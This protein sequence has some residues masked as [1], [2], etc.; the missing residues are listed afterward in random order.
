MS[1]AQGKTWRIGIRKAEGRWIVEKP[2]GKPA[3]GIDCVEWTLHG[4]KGA[5][6]SAHFQFTNM[7]L[8]ENH[9]GRQDLTR[10]MTA[11]IAGPGEMLTLKVQADADRRLHPRYYAV[12]IRDETHEN[13]GEFAVGEEGNPPPELEVGP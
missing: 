8:F 10:D 3:K 4:E 9:A 13:G 2:K 5:A 1:E 11:R 7:D 6:V 12:W